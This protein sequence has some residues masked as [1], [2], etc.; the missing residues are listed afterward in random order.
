MR[1]IVKAKCHQRSSQEPLPPAFPPKISNISS[2]ITVNE[3][4]NV[5][6]VC[7]ANGRPEP[8]ITWRHLTPTVF[9]MVRPVTAELEERVLLSLCGRFRTDRASV[10]ETFLRVLPMGALASAFSSHVDGSLRTGEEE[11]KLY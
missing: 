4:S 5:T 7:M 11:T 10:T 6:L 8:V 3:G 9:S 2:D 1:S